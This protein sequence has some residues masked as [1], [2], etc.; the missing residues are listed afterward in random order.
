METDYLTAWK[1]AIDS[2]EPWVIV[3]S[4]PWCPPCRILK[5]KLKSLKDTGTK[6]QY[7]V[8]PSTGEYAQKLAP[9]LTVIPVWFVYQYDKEAKE[10]KLLHKQ[11]GIDGYETTLKKFVEK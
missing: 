6:F 9:G 4:E 3:I 1:A 11:V 2:G 8:L 7:T 5:N 10:F